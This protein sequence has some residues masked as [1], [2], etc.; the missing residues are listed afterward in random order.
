MECQFFRINSLASDFCIEAIFRKFSDRPMR[1]LLLEIDHMKLATQ[2]T[3]HPSGRSTAL[4]LQALRQVRS[5]IKLW[6]VIYKRWT[7]WILYYNATTQHNEIVCK[8][9]DEFTIL[10]QPYIMCRYVAY[11]RCCEESRSP[12]KAFI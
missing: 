12:K 2:L 11:L 1:C 6:I 7:T 10:S 8:M 9:K 5:E 4:L 3:S